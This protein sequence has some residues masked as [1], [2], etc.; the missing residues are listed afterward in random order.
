[1]IMM[2]YLAIVYMVDRRHS[3]TGGTAMKLSQVKTSLEVLLPTRRPVFLWGAPG[4]GKSQLIAQIAKDNGLSFIDARLAN[5]DP[6]DLYGLPRINGDNRAHWAIPDFLPRDGQGI[7]FLDEFV[8]AAPS[9]Q[10]AASQLILDRRLG[11]YNLPDGWVVWAA[12]NRM[13][14][15]AA[16]NRMPSHLANRF[17]HLDVDVDLDDWVKW[18]LNHDIA[19]PLIGFIRFR[20]ELLHKFDSKIDDRAFPTPRAWEFVSQILTQNPKKEIE[21]ELIKGTVGEGAAAELVGFLRIFR[22]LPNPDAIM[23]NPA[24]ADVPTDPATLYALCGALARKAS[25]N[26]IGRLVE[27]YNR[28]PAEFS[29]LAVRD[30]IKVAPEVVN[31]RAFIEWASAHSEILI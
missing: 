5:M 11:E 25:D 17:I 13:T 27:Y 24:A 7:L 8:Q 1:M 23:L 3:L 22:S 12:G 28:L 10:N 18:A 20:P 6:V 14:D 16:T 26:T 21:Y 31:S 9:I 29:V 4:V 19:T 15:R 30:S 2:I